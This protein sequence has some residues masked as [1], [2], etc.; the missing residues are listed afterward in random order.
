MINPFKEINW[1][2]DTK[3]RKKFALSL[4]I[5]FPAIGILL[6][7][8]GW[9]KTGVWDKNLNLSLWIGGIGFFAGIAFYIFH[10]I[11]KPFYIIWYFLASCI[12][13]VISNLVLAL[14]YYLILTPFGIVRQIVSKDSFPKTFDKSKKTYWQDAPQVDDIKRYYK[15]F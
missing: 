11:S 12:G 14:F 15:Q 6:L 1:N 2:P 13:F 8:L 3:E 7:L 9:I 4:L 5:G 10:Q